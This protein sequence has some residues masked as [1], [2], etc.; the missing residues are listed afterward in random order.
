[1]RLQIGVHEKLTGIPLPESRG[2]V[3][4]FNYVMARIGGHARGREQ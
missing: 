3:V 2:A 1:V 4:T